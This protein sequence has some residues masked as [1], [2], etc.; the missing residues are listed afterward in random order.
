MVGLTLISESLQ[1]ISIY[2]FIW[3]DIWQCLSRGGDGRGVFS[4]LPQTGMRQG[5][6]LRTLRTVVWLLFFGISWSC[7]LNMCFENCIWKIKYMTKIKLKY[8][9]KYIHQSIFE[10][11]KYKTNCILKIFLGHLKKQYFPSLGIANVKHCSKHFNAIRRHLK[12]Y[13]PMKTL[14]LF[15][16]IRF[17]AVSAAS[18]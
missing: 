3:T 6:R 2:A 4:P 12:E 5:R 9:A 16:V 18:S 17:D 15:G 10:M 7:I 1:H 14:N 11:P 8:I 13:F